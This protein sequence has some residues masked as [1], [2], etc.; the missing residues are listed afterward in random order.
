MAA[1]YID[2]FEPIYVFIMW[3]GSTFDVPKDIYVSFFNAI[4]AVSLIK[5][6]ELYK[7]K[8]Y[9]V[10]L[11]LSNF[12]LLVIFTGA[13]RLKFAYLII[14]VSL[15]AKKKYVQNLI[16]I[17]PLAHLQASIFVAPKIIL[18]LYDTNFK[19]ISGFFRNVFI[20]IF[21]FI[22]FYFL[23]DGLISKFK[24]HY[25]SSWDITQV[26]QLSILLLIY[27]I[28]TKKL[29]NSFLIFIPLFFLAIIIGNERVNMIGFTFIT[30][31][32]MKSN[33]LNH[34][35]YISLLIYFVYKSFIFI[36]TIIEFGDGFV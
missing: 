13:E 17:S 15:I 28:I 27:L 18:F 16:Y 22:L 33:K 29:K 12:Y 10:L 20:I 24:S 3:I 5:L 1:F 26:F 11:L 30:F 4:L 25:I 7:V 9:I 2:S 6:C 32:L 14:I 31:I 36:S 35:L 23:K 19:K 8:W 34:P 21:F